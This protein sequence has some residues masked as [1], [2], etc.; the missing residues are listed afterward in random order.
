MLFM[1]QLFMQQKI[2][3]GNTIRESNLKLNEIFI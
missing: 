3:D 1:Q 2:Y